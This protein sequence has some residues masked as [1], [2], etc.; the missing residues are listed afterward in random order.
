M[1]AGVSDYVWKIEEL[2]PS[3]TDAIHPEGQR[4]PPSALPIPLVPQTIGRR[5][6]HLHQLTFQ[7]PPE[8]PATDSKA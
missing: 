6:H 2:S 7:P 4:H 8:P 5:T 1:A 3:S